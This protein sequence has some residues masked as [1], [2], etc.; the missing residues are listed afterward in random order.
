MSKAIQ[1]TQAD[2]DRIDHAARVAHE[3]NRAWCVANGDDSQPS[4]E[5]A[6]EWQKSSA[7]NG[8]MFHM[9]NPEA[10]DSASHDSWMAE[11]VAAGWVYGDVKD[12]DA[13]PPT[14]PCIVPFEQ[15]PKHQ[16]IKDAI[17]RSIVHAIMGKEDNTDG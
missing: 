17:F 10:G 2:V 1:M 12:P 11:K 13:T 16:Q 5:E 3:T 15:L 9:S 6:P 7:V 8:V 14:H 4:W